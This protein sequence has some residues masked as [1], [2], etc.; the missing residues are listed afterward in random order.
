V[1]CVSRETDGKGVW[2]CGCVSRETDGK[3]VW[4]CESGN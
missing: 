1:R 4:V 3:G 2:V